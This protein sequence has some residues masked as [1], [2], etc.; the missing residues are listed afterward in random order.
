MVNYWLAEPKP[1]VRL[2]CLRTFVPRRGGLRLS[3]PSRRRLEGVGKLTS[4]RADLVFEQVQPAYICLFSK[5]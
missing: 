5:K 2:A 4:A 1:A 3:L